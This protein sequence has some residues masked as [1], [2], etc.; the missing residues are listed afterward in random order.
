MAKKTFD[1]TIF[2]PSRRKNSQTAGVT[3]QNKGCSTILPNNPCYLYFSSRKILKRR[4]RGLRRV[5]MSIS[6]SN[7]TSATAMKYWYCS[8]YSS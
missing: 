1:I 5:R 7:S 2:L 3:P 4:N 8:L 6:S